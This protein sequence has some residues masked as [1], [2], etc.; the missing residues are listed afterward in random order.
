MRRTIKRAPSASTGQGPVGQGT[1]V[2][3]PQIGTLNGPKQAPTSTQFGGHDEVPTTQSTLSQ[4][5]GW[6]A[7]VARNIL[8][9]PAGRESQIK[10]DYELQVGEAP[11]RVLRQM[12]E[13]MRGNI[14]PEA[15]Q[16]TF[17][18]NAEWS[19]IPHQWVPRAAMR[20]GPQTRM[21]NDSQNIPAVY[22]GNTRLG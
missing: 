10:T 22:A 7:N 18:Y 13:R 8:S 9:R 1:V 15:G 20:S 12:F 17:P 5:R 19:L 21:F 3:T 6:P 2:G 4:V 16:A 11:P 14:G